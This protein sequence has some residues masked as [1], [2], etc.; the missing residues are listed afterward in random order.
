[1]AKTRAALYAFNRGIVS[2]SA[3][4]RVD[5]ERL[6]LSAETQTNWMPSVLGPMTLRPGFE[7]IG[8]T[9]NNSVMMPIPFVF[10]TSDTAILQLTDSV[11][12]VMISDALVSYDSVS[13]TVTNGDFSS[14]AGWTLATAGGGSASI[15]GG[16]LNLAG[17]AT[18]GSASCTRSVTVASADLNVRHSL[19]IVVERG[20]LF[21]RC[22]STSGGDDYIASS[23]LETGYHALELTPTGTFYVQFENREIPNKIVDSITVGAAGTLELPTPWLE[24]DLP[25]IR[26]FQSA[27]V[28]FVTCIGRQQRRIERRAARSWSV[29][30]YK[31]DDGPFLSTTD[32]TITITPS[33]TKGNI[34]L[35]ASRDLFRSTHVGSIWRLFQDGQTVT[36]TVAAENN[37]SSAIRVTGVGT[38]RTFTYEVAGTFTATWTLQRSFT[39]ESTGFV[40][41][42]TGTAAGVASLSD[43]FNNSIVWYRIG[44]KTGDFSSGSLDFTLRYPGG[45]GS[46]IARITGYTNRTTVDAEVLDEFSGTVATDNW[47]EGAWSDYR[48]F[49]TAITLHEGRLW[50]ATGDHMWGSVSDDY[51]SYDYEASGDSAPIDRT[52]GYGPVFKINW[53]LP[54]SRLVIGREGSEISVRSSSFDEPLTPTNFNMKDC[55]TQ[56]SSALPALKVDTKGMFVQQSGK[57]VYELAYNVQ[58]QDYGTTDLTRLCPDLLS[59]VSAL[60]VQRQ[61]ETVLF[62]NQADGNTQALTYESDDQVNAWWTIETNGV[63]ENMCV[64]PGAPEDAVYATIRRTIGGSTVRY[65]EKMARL[66]QC[67]GLMEARLADSHYLYADVETTTISGLD[68]LEGETVVVWGWNDINP[69][70][71][72]LADGTTQEVG[73]DFGTFTVSGGAI[74]GLSDEVTHACVG[75]AYDAEFKSAKLAYATQGGTALTIKK[76]VNRIGLVMENTHYQGVRY[77]RNAESTDELPLVESEF[78][79][80]DDTVW[81]A[82]DKPMFALAGEWDTDHRLTL[83]AAAPRPAS[84]LAVA[85]EVQSNE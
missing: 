4:T 68:H 60:A 17:V 40:D 27:D 52:I 10:S 14:S 21:F 48:G 31:A 19:R 15:S 59:N 79:T 22:G 56:G 47:L 8:A 9:K 5:I 18:G 23:L 70:T 37:F 66:D 57:R 55:S 2:R 62:F 85:I 53:L 69:F 24:S 13:T 77:G 72:T 12:R 64:V 20:P 76:K 58:I 38:D 11:M 73:K 26:Y 32:D 30:L 51:S 39:S 36:A 3:L 34:T 46:G 83:V 71:V 33:A 67:T 61:P 80:E 65:F 35:T 49:P 1:M 29:V 43:G 82:Y 16:K 81:S 50:Q 84:I 78:T 75:L 54:L 7:Y 41:V 25:F 6:R 44:V 28:I 63:I 74:S 45:G 42:T